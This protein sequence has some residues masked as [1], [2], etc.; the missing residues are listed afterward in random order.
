MPTIT[1]N[2]VAVTP[3]G[4]ITDDMIVGSYVLFSIPEDLLSLRRVRKAFTDAGLDVDWLP[5]ERRPEHVAQ[6][7]IRKIERVTTNGHREEIR[8]EQVDRNKSFLI[9]QVTRHVQDKENRVIEHPKAMRV[10]FTFADSSLSYEPLE[11]AT[12]RDVQSLIDEIETNYAANASK[13][14]GHKLR[15]IMRHYMEAAGAERMT[16]GGSSYFLAKR[17][18][19]ATWNRL[20]PH[21]GAV[22]DGSA[23]LASMTEALETVYGDKTEFHTI[24]CVNDEGQRAYLKR[25][26]MENCAED[27]KSF[28]DE[29]LELVS[30]K[31][32]RIRG[33]RGDLRDRLLNTRAQIDARRAQFAE[34]LG[35]T[36]GELDRDMKLADSALSK[37]ITEAGF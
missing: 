32:K 6:E 23:L 4:D 19:V 15:T 14:P 31:D 28:R 25:K 17:C 18:P 7:A 37:F 5:K 29:C 16:R 9:Y 10:I 12:Q 27:L 36:M 3:G 8:V 35:E 13:I 33:F 34:I 20:Y 11:G 24:P 30:E 21:H 2:L 1:K 22:I 26:F